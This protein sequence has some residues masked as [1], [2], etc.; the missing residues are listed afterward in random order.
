MAPGALRGMRQRVAVLRAVLTPAPVLAL[1]E[2]FGALDA[3]TEEYLA[4]ARGQAG[5]SPTEI[6]VT[7][8]L[9]DLAANA[10]RALE[11]RTVKR[12]RRGS[13]SPTWPRTTTRASLPPP[14]RLDSRPCR[15]SLPP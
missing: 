14:P 7:K 15:S 11:G 10:R 2:P 13:L 1:D 6:D 12:A 9:S 8:L 5:E 3:L 4:F